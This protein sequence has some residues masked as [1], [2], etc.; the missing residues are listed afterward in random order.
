MSERTEI[1]EYIAG[2][3]GA[4]IG[5]LQVSGADGGGLSVSLTSAPEA[6]RLLDGSRI[7]SISLKFLCGDKSQIKALNRLCAVCS[8]LL[9][10]KDFEYGIFGVSVTSEPFY[11][12]RDTVFW[13]YSCG[14]NL[15]YCDEKDV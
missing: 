3:T 1:L 6:V 15:F 4:V 11:S 10:K 13:Y 12:D 14:V 7:E 8:L 9:E 2:L 5:Q